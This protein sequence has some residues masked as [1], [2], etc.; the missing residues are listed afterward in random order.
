MISSQSQ[1]DEITSTSQALNSALTSAETVPPPLKILRVSPSGLHFHSLLRF[2]T[3]FNFLQES[4]APNDIPFRLFGNSRYLRSIRRLVH[5]F[6]DIF[7]PLSQFY[8][9]TDIFI[10]RLNFEGLFYKFSR[11]SKTKTKLFVH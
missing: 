7:Y 4:E 5:L 11:P 3:V 1:S 9:T 10:V 2:L 8:C 6:F